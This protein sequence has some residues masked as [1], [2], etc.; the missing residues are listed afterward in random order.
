MATARNEMTAAMTVTAAEA[1]VIAGANLPSVFLLGGEK[2]GSTSLAFALS[3]H[4]Q[5]QMARHAL[6]GEPAFFRKESHFFDDD[7]RFARGVSFGVDTGDVRRMLRVWRAEKCLSDE[8]CW[9]ACNARTWD[10]SLAERR[11]GRRPTTS[12]TC[13]LRACLRVR[14]DGEAKA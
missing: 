8:F 12:P 6:P 5:I 7:L 2:C 14:R 1:R 13:S 3:R 11:S 4:P 9:A 10:A